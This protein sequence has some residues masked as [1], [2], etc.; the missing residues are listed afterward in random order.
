MMGALYDVGTDYVARTGLAV[1]HQGEQI[2][3]AEARKPFTGANMGAPPSLTANFHIQ[4]WD[5]RGVQHWLA[6]GGDKIIGSA[7][8]KYMTRNPSARPVY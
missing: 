6:T 1:I 8:S 2:V 4:A 7:V 5:A 3:P